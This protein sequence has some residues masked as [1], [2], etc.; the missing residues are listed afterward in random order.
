MGK[1]FEKAERKALHSRW[2]HES[3]GTVEEFLGAEPVDPSGEY[4][5]VLALLPQPCAV[6]PS[7]AAMSCYDDRQRGVHIRHR[8]EKILDPFV[9]NE[10]PNV[11]DVVITPQPERGEQISGWRGA[12][13]TS[14]IWDVEDRSPVAFCETLLDVFR[15]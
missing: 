8:C 12:Y 3:C 14:R 4:R 15:D 1:A 13:R 2:Q 5:P 10:A 9:G 7:V 11:Q 6:L